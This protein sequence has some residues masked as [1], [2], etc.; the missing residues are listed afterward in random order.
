MDK[1]I[2]AVSHPGKMG[3]ALYA[4]PTARALCELWDAEADFYTSEYCKPMTRLVE[5]QSYIRNVIIPPAYRILRK[6]VGVQPWQ[7]PIAVNLYHKVAHLGFRSVPFTNIPLFIAKQV[8]APL[9]LLQR[10]Y[11]DYPEIDTLDEPYICVA[12]RGNTTYKGLFRSVVHNSPVAAVV[13]GGPIDS[14]TEEKYTNHDKP[15]VD[16][17]GLDMLETVSWLSKCVGFVGLM[18]AM[19]VLANGFDM[20]KIVPHDGIHWD[21]R[22]VLY[23]DSH[24]YLV[25]P[26]EQD[27]FGGLGL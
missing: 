26:T 13:I 6:D 5:Y 10:I 17:C 12:P 24:K 18:S 22:H 2:I 8:G 27:I 4:L 1:N 15:I 14:I 23:T 19:L 21:M 25:A 16:L 7:M 20:P 3:D 9:E 11:Y